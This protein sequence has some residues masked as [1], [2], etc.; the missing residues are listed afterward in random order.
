MVAYVDGR[1]LPS[2]SKQLDW[3]LH[4]NKTADP[5]P[6]NTFAIK[7]KRSRAQWFLHLFIRSTKAFLGMN[8]PSPAPPSPFF[9]AMGLRPKSHW[10][11]LVSPGTPSCKGTI[12]I[13]NDR[14]QLG[15]WYLNLSLFLA[16]NMMSI[17]CQNVRS[18]EPLQFPF[19]GAMT[20]GC[21]N[22]P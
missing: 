4:G 11:E 21:T 6:G 9:L 16:C 7:P 15:F 8:L 20:R 1:L 10:S 17:L 5:A 14:S 3:W 13:F 2:H 12:L 18:Q 19:S 22:P